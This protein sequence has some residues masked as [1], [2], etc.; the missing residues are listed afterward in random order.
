MTGTTVPP[1]AVS[2][3][4]G[5]TVPPQVVST[6]TGTT[7]PPQV[8]STVTGTTVPP[9]VVS[10]VTGTTVPPQVVSSV[11]GTTVPPQVVST[12]TG[13][14][15]PPQVVSTV[16]GTTVPPHSPPLIDTVV[17][18]QWPSIPAIGTLV[19]TV[20]VYSPAAPMG[21]MRLAPVIDIL[22]EPGIVRFMVGEPARLLMVWTTHV[23]VLSEPETLN[24]TP[25]HLSSSDPALEWMVRSTPGI[26][27]SREGRGGGRGVEAQR[28]EGT[29]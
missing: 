7:V 28:D 6:V 1:Q 16:T 19:H 14:T 23:R 2:T 9:Q 29:V 8:V 26:G 10:T 18:L 4:T 25:R 22:S 5:T 27:S 12:V 11:T 20:H 3:V 24:S 15:V 17:L 13:T 21:R